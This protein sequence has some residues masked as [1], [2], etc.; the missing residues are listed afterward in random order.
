MK[1]VFTWT[2]T[3]IDPDGTESNPDWEPVLMNI[4]DTDEEILAALWFYACA[5]EYKR[6]LLSAGLK[7]DIIERKRVQA[8]AQE[9]EQQELQFSD[10]VVLFDPF[11]GPV[12]DSQLRE[13]VE[14]ARADSRRDR[15]VG[16]NEFTL[17]PPEGEMI[18]AVTYQEDGGAIVAEGELCPECGSTATSR[19]VGCGNYWKCEDCS[20]AWDDRDL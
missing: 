11:A 9:R 1:I 12:T 17:Q 10:P 13:I 2:H 19:E 16:R 7:S 18:G 6:P 5:V 4:E 3:T 20:T 14:Q 15:L 8:E